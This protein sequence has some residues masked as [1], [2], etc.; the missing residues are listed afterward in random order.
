VNLEEVVIRQLMGDSE[1]R[2][3]AQVTFS[4]WRREHVGTTVSALAILCGPPG[5]ER[6]LGLK[7]SAAVP[8]AQVSAPLS[9]PREKAPLD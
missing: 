5:R 9:M 2:A 1:R 3:N 6:C 7:L 8:M 4:V